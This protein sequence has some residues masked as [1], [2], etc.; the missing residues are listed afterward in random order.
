M[1]LKVRQKSCS[2]KTLCL[3]AWLEVISVINVFREYSSANGI[4]QG[5]CRPACSCAGQETSWNAHNKQ[6]KEDK[7]TP[8]YSYNFFL[9]H[10][11][12]HFYKPAQMYLLPLLLHFA[13][14]VMLVAKKS[15][16]QGQR[17]GGFFLST[18]PEKLGKLKWSILAA[19]STRNKPHAPKK[20]QGKGYAFK[21]A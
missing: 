7:F 12:P 1:V 10:T 14:W 15:T 2:Y 11:W 13:H 3:A 16:S 19:K 21:C 4:M 20:D 17:S 9:P 6:H 8:L 18:G 5:K